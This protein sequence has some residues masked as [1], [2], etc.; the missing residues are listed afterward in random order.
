MTRD[1]LNPNQANA[2]QAK[3][4][5]DRARAA[6]PFLSAEGEACVSVPMDNIDARRIYSLRSAEF[7]DWLINACYNEFESVPSDGSLR[8]ALRMLEARARHGEM[9]PQKVDYRLGFDGDPYAPSRMFVDL[10]SDQECMTAGA[11]RE[12]GCSRK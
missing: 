5:L 6:T 11:L 2:S 1:N 4:I 12:P 8:A 7:R 3:A 9:A 10:A